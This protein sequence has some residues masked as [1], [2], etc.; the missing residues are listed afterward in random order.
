MEK[1]AE[2]SPAGRNHCAG[3]VRGLCG[4]CAAQVLD[5]WAMGW[6]SRWQ[7]TAWRETNRPEKITIG[8]GGL[9]EVMVN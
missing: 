2:L 6:D 8:Y 7:A 1:G 5:W 4:D 9:W 3:I